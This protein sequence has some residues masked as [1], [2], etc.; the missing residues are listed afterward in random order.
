MLSSWLSDEASTSA[1]FSCRGGTF[2]GESTSV[3]DMA[4]ETFKNEKLALT[5][6][7]AAFMK[8]AQ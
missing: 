2:V 7:Q 5:I 4:D 3:S 6:S 1:V 8:R